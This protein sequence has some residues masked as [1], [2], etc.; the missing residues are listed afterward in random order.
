MGFTEQPET[1]QHRSKDTFSPRQAADS[2]HTFIHKHSQVGTARIKSSSRSVFLSV[3]VQRGD[4]AQDQTEERFRFRR[5][6][7]RFCR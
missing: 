5:E 4:V 7:T 6:K 1:Q 2:S 3:S